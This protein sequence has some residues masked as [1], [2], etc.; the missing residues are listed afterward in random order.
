MLTNCLAAW[1]SITVCEIERDI[2][3]KNPHFI[4]PL[5]FDAPIRGVPVGMSEPHLVRKN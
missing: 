2:S 4:I 3:E 5:A 1:V